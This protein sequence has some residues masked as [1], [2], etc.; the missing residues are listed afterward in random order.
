LYSLR[1]TGHTTPSATGELGTLLRAVDVFVAADSGLT[2]CSP[3]VTAA[4][5]GVPL[6]S[7]TTDSA[8]DLVLTGAVGRLTQ[9]RPDAIAETVLAIVDEGMS[10]RRTTVSG[11]DA[12][13]K[14]AELA[15]HLLQVYRH[16]S[17]EPL[18]GASK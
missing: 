13:R 6:V 5:A 4:E 10:T 17:L 2:A 3:A 7:V 11:A 18:T 14:A 1:L 15:H 12:P 9:P 16:V 8:Q